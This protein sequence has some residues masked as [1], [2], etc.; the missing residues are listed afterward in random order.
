MKN[1][2]YSM[3]TRIV[4]E[5]RVIERLGE[6]IPKVNRVTV[7]TGQSFA[8]RTGL[9]DRLEAILR[10]AGVR[11]VTFAAASPNPPVSEVEAAAKLARE[12]G[13]ELLIGLGGGSAMDA[14]KAAAVLATNNRP[15]MELF[16]IHSFE[17][18]SLP[19]VCIPTTA[20]TGSETTQYAIIN[21]DEGTDKLNLNSPRTFPLVALLDPELSVTMPKGVT[22]DT[23]LD[24]LSHAIEGYLSSRSQPLA[25]CLALESIRAVKEYLPRAVRNAQDLDARAGMLYAA[26]VAGMVIAQAGTIMLHALGY[27]LT[28]KY[29][30]PHGRAN[31]TLLGHC[32]KL[33]EGA[34]P[35]KLNR[36]YS[37]FNA[38]REGHIAFIDFVRSVGVPTNIRA[39]GVKEEDL[40][41]F[42]EYVMARKNVPRT[43]GTVTKADV[44]RLLIEAL[45]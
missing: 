22:A 30:V 14:A 19:L 1:F 9:C 28:L 44:E 20:G 3:P 43:P 27:Y 33:I 17:N 34:C 5:R 4:L 38:E 10:D 21:N 16:P 12:T 18:A 41:T 37:I 26:A 29:G 40:D 6:F 13:A 15:L 11:E 23:G 31:G 35:E 25:N 32:L 2:S 36:I 39:Y 42:R 8:R 45:D 7:V 24:A